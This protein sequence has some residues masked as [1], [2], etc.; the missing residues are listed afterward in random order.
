MDR[1]YDKLLEKHFNSYSQMAFLVGPRQVGKTTISKHC[2]KLTD[3]YVYLNWDYMEDQILMLEGASK[4]I[5][6]YRLNKITSRKAILAFDEIHKYQHW[7]NYLK[8]LYDKYSE[9]LN[10]IITG[11]AKLDIFRTTGDSL[12][13]RYLPYNIHPL[14]VREL[15]DTT[16]PDQEIKAP[17]KIDPKLFKD[18][19]T[20]GGFPN[21]LLK[22]DTGFYKRW[23]KLRS[24][25]LFD[26]DIRNIT[27][28]HEIAQL[29]L[30]SMILK[31]QAGELLNYARLSKKV[32]VTIDTIKAWIGTLSGFY[33]C[34]S[35]T[36]WST[37]V[38]RS[39]IKTPKLYLWDWSEIEDIGA[40]HENIV[41]CHLKKA[42]DFW[43]DTGLGNYQLF[44]LRDK[45]KNEVDF[46]VTKDSKPWFLVEV[47]S[48]DTSMSQSLY[49]FQ[50]QTKA[51]HAFQV[52]FNL[53][54]VD[55]DC[56]EY[57]TPVVVP[58]MTF[59]SQ[60]V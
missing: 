26:D 20:C 14:S 34:F 19:I 33:Y 21:P 55:K 54:Y 58:A 31:Q 8:G 18:L 13:G 43:N 5:E 27:R 24:E 51:K 48:S 40:K 2:E 53:D 41:A 6:K 30:L 44:F 22:Q 56:F 4:V 25:Q 3:N 9:S 32:G 38:I 60:L 42:I 35:I 29:K 12:M 11:S 7:R 1:I 28:I 52:V 59:L 37:N 57:T 49:R 10:F 46:L 47:K 45:E 23:I 16:L 15:I 17:L 36:P 50:E 39:L